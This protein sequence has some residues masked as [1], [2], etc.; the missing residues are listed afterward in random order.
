MNS[1]YAFVVGPLAWFAWGVFILG[2][3]YRLVSMYQLAKAKDGSS[4]HYMSFKYGMRSIFAWLN[5]SGT[6]GWQRNPW[7]AMMTF[8]FHICLVIVPLFLLGHVVLWDQF[9][10]ISWPTLPDQIADIMSI[11]VVVCCIYF[12]L[13]RFLQKDV[14]YLTTGKDWI[15][16]AVPALVFLTG[17]LSYHEIGDA[18]VMLIL[19]I[20]CGEIM[21]M[22]IPF[23][24]LSHMLFG[25]FTRAYMGSE[26]GGVR[27]CKDW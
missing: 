21:L 11:V 19:H 10:G 9:F 8:V 14:A 26:F 24:R 6:L 3:A 27:R 15:A 17:V 20:L 4:L 23:T 13:R 16:L 7:T 25:L 18:K 5:P 22:S 2:S 1:V 12:G